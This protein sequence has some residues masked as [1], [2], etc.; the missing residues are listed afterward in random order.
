MN[1]QVDNSVVYINIIGVGGGGNNAVNRMIENGISGVSYISINTDNGAVKRSKAKTSLQIGMRETKGYGAGADPI[2]GKRSAEESEDEIKNAIKDCD[3]VFITSGMGGGT[4]TGAAPVIAKIAKKLGILT[5]AVVTTPFS[6][7][8]K[9]RKDQANE[10]IKQLEK[11]VD[12]II[13]IPNDNLKK[14][15]EEKIT[16][17]NAFALADDVLMQ[18]VKN[19]VELIQKNA[20]IN[21][22]FADI[23]SILKDSGRVH[24]AIGVGDVKEVIEQI[25]ENKLLESTVKDADSVLFC[26]TTSEETSLYDIDLICTEISENARPKANIIFGVDFD[27]SMGEDIKAI[28]IATK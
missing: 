4:G 18:T 13:I 12:A 17:S 26:I 22:D 28:L 15:A 2:K 3:M 11:N 9:R 16:F 7:E 1:K 21:C 25:K 24:T 5:V 14:V 27:K 23:K 19:M 6:F 8:G 10:G 20:Y